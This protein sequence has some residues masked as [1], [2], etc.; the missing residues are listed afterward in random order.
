MENISIIS[1]RSNKKS[2][3]AEDTKALLGVKVLDRSIDHLKKAKRTLQNELKAIGDSKTKNLL[4][5]QSRKR[6]TKRSPQKS[7]ARNSQGIRA[8]RRTQKSQ[9]RSFTKA[10]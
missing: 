7:P 6:K 5:Q 9:R 3:I 2:N 8:A 1:F 10:K 4:Q